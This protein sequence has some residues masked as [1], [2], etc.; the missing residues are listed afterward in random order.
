[1]EK[2][3]IRKD[4]NGNIISK[5]EKNYHITICENF[6][7]IIE[8]PSFKKYNILND[9]YNDDDEDEEE[10]ENKSPFVENYNIRKVENVSTKDPRG[11]SKVKCIII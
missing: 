3:K 7:T 6:V 2:I 1:M 11:N 9:D 8:V 5:A 4:A 10:V